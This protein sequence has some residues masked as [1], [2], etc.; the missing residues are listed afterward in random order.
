M[1]AWRRDFDRLITRVD[2][3]D[4]DGTR[5]VAVLQ[6]QMT[7]LAKDV[8]ELKGESHTW[9]E[10]HERQ[11]MAD[12]AE[13]VSGRRWLVTTAIAGLASMATAIGLLIDIASHVH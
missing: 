2:S 9:Q 10:A 3:I 6:A 12:A 13:R 5:G 8:A 11:H 7:D 1:N 4:R